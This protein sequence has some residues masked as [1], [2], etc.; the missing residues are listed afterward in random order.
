MPKTHY[1][2]QHVL[3]HFHGKNLFEFHK[4]TGQVSPRNIRKAAQEIDLY[5][6]R[7][8]RGLFEELDNYSALLFKETIYK[9]RY[10]ALDLC[11]KQR[12]SEW[13]L[14]FA[15]RIPL[16]LERCEQQ[17]R[18]W[19]ENPIEKITFVRK[20]MSSVMAQLAREQPERYAEAVEKMGESELHRILEERLTYEMLNRSVDGKPGFVQM[21]ESG[22]HRKFAYHLYKMQW[23]WLWTHGDFI[24]SDNPL[25]CWHTKLKKVGHGLS[26]RHLEMTIPLTKKVALYMHRRDVYPENAICNRVWTKNLNRRQIANGYEKLYGP[27]KEQ[28]EKLL[29]IHPAAKG[30]L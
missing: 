28:L 20:E 9:Q 3:R 26:G 8:E 30:A 23:T 5:P 18:H 12:L 17:A 27:S 10:I 16:N 1:L 4:A 13:L 11:E 7:L 2:P 6:E 19:N 21:H 14:L 29:G 24:I 22:N 15:I 25:C